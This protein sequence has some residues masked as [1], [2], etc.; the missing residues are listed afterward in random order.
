MKSEAAEYYSPGRLAVTIL[1][2]CERRGL[3][4]VTF[5]GGEPMHQAYELVK[6]LDLLRMTVRF[7]F[8]IGMYTGY[9]PFELQTGRYEWKRVNRGGCR[10][11]EAEEL[12]EKI[13]IWQILRNHLDFAVMGRFNQQQL[14]SSRPMCSSKNQELKLFS[15]K[16]TLEDFPPQQAEVLITDD[17]VTIT[18]FPTGDLVYW[19]LCRKDIMGL[20]VFTLSSR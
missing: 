18:G 5:S 3:N 2:T 6:A 1:D 7:G 9:T 11:D 13:A 15:K 20:G 19:L 10:R 12:R 4:A 8:S 16:Y 17:L 14:D